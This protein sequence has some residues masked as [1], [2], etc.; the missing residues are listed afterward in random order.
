[1]NLLAPLGLAALVAIP[2]ILVFHMRHTTPPRRVVPSLRFWE[3]AQP[4]PSAERRFRRPPLTLPLVLQLIAAALLAVARIVTLPLKCPRK[5]RP[6][7]TSND[8]MP[9]PW[10]GSIWMID[11]GN[12]W[13]D[14]LVVNQPVVHHALER[15][16]ENVAVVKAFVA[17][18]RER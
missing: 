8:S 7:Y 10:L 4:R 2:I 17:G 13:S 9:K 15:S 16:A 14:L 12:M 18:A 3:A 1:M 6:P 11:D 5:G